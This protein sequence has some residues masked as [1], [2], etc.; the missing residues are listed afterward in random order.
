MRFLLDTHA[1]IWFGNGDPQLSA[2]AQNLIA[3]GTNQ[4]YFSV[5][6]SF[7]MAIKVNIG[8]L[9]LAQSLPSFLQSVAEKNIESLPLQ[10]THLSRYTALPVFPDHRDPFDRM[11][12]ATAIA[13]SLTIITADQKFDLYKN[14][15]NVE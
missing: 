8:K 14:L 12:I 15:I 13:E 6:G 5:A 10:E 2:K 9:Q 4:I 3:D 11:I 7:E 1:L